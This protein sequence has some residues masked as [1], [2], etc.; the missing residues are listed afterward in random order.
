MLLVLAALT[1]L[2]G[3]RTS[4]LP[5]KLCPVVKTLA[6]VLLLLGSAIR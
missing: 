2:T 5:I 4:A 3:A 6:A 1:A